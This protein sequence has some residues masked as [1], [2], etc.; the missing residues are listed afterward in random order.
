MVVRVFITTAVNSPAKTT[1]TTAIPIIAGEPKSPNRHM[2]RRASPANTSPV[3]T[4]TD[5][6]IIKKRVLYLNTFLIDDLYLNESRFQIKGIFSSKILPPFFG[7]FGRKRSAGA[8]F[9]SFMPMENTANNVTKKITLSE[10]K[11]KIWMNYM[12]VC[13]KLKTYTKKECINKFLKN[14]EKL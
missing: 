1:T 14:V 4:P 13:V 3:E 10:I 2:S 7:G 6:S 12:L 5:T 11:K 8:L 9:A